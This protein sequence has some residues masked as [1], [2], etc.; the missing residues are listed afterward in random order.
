MTEKEFYRDGKKSYFKDDG[1]LRLVWWLH[2]TGKLEEKL[3]KEEIEEINQYI[4]EKKD[5]NLWEI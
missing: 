5:P 4:K 3:S 1:H 2:I